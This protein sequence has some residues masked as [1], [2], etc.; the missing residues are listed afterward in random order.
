MSAERSFSAGDGTP[1][2]RFNSDDP[3]P[4][5]WLLADTQNSVRVSVSNGNERWHN[6]LPFGEPVADPTGLPGDRG[7][8]GQ[9]HDTGGDLRL[10]KRS[11]P[12]QM[13]V[14][15][16]P[17]ALMVA[18]D[19]QSLNAYDV[20]DRS[21]PVLYVARSDG[22]AATTVRRRKLKTACRS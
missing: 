21:R 4:W 17:D 6:Y 20:L 9:V 15:T 22:D 12:V 2:A 13:N 19:P 14:L 10:D 11:Y 8:L 7:H 16:T 1:L 5:T 18:T 3:T